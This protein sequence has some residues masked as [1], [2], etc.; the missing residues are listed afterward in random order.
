MESPVEVEYEI[1][2]KYKTTIYPDVGERETVSDAIKIQTKTLEYFNE[3]LRY[4]LDGSTL[5][6]VK[7]LHIDGT[8][9]VKRK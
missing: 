6:S 8:N 2:M 5:S 3:D 7:V 4:A 9:S 1:V